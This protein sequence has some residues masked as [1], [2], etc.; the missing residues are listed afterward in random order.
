MDVRG[1]LPP[2]FNRPGEIVISTWTRQSLGVPLIALG[3]SAAGQ[4]YIAANLVLYI[5]FHVPEA[6]ILTKLF[7][8]NGNA[9]T[10]NLDIGLYQTDGTL[11]V[12]SG[13]TAQTGTN[14]IQITDITDT[15]IARGTYYFGIVGDTTGATQKLFAA[16]PAVGI[17]QALGILEQ[18]SVTLPLATNASPAT[19][20]AVSHAFVPI[21]GALAYRAVGP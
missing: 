17:M 21:I 7:W 9:V 3:Q 10:G 13:T 18:A 1:F 8:V 2:M 14:T 16:L 12:S 6:T 11:L 19:F 15:A 4:G 5:P 20:A